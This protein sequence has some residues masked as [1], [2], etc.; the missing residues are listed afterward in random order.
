MLAPRALRAA[1]ACERVSGREAAARRRASADSSSCN[2]RA[3]CSSS[4]GGAPS[5]RSWFVA[6]VS[7][8]GAAPC[9]QRGREREGL[10]AESTVCAGTSCYRQAQQTR[11]DTFLSPA[12]HGSARSAYL[13][14]KQGVWLRRWLW[15][16]ALRPGAA[17]G[18]HL[19][20]RP[21]YSNVL[22]AGASSVE[23]ASAAG[24]RARGML[25][26]PVPDARTQP[27]RTPPASGMARSSV[28]QRAARAG[29][30]R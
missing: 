5:C 28:E 21:P 24:S 25:K 11:L 20:S 4:S 2:C 18:L 14:V 9:R 30:I 26:I 8:R 17:A 1:A 27:G 3:S 6:G 15:R 7:C 12:G 16:P 22:P 29:R 19:A 13:V 10:S 23:R